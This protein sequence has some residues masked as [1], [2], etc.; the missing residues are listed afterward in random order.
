LLTERLAHAKLDRLAQQIKIIRATDFSYTDCLDALNQLQ[1]LCE[2][3]RAGLRGMDARESI[4]K[5]EVVHELN[6][7]VLHITRVLGIIIQSS[8]TRNAF[9]F[10]DPFSVICKK[11]IDKDCKLIISSEWD[12]MPFTFAQNM[13]GLPNFVI[14]GLPASESDNVLVFPVAG[15][16]LGHS[17]WQKLELTKKFQLILHRRISDNFELNKEKL[18]KEFPG[19]KTNDLGYDVEAQ[20]Q[21]GYCVTNALGCAEEIF[22]DFIALLIFGESY[23]RAFEYLV[24]PTITGERSEKYPENRN[25]AII[26]ARY[27][28]KLEIDDPY[29]YE[30]FK[31]DSVNP[32]VGKKFL[33]QMT[34]LGVEETLDELFAAA[35]IHLTEC[36]I[37]FPK[38]IEV[39]GVRKWFD[40]GM[41][42]PR[43]TSLGV[44]ITAAWSCFKSNSS[45]L[46]PALGRENQ[47]LVNDLT[48]KS[49]EISEYGKFYHV[50]T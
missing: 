37:A 4:V 31:I 19:I 14:I 9:E 41:P 11:A 38:T 30:N 36:G 45:E 27:A 25:R 12:Y 24:A 6:F 50:V 43:S 18:A 39:T 47:Q 7:N 40:R 8:S 2:T 10:F 34:D 1:E 15:H 42:C 22:C 16:E 48:L 26:L 17:V 29:Y 28:K 33:M 44:L 23:L 13:I 46:H 3:Q 5:N 32:D 20:I 35:Q 21:L 49:A